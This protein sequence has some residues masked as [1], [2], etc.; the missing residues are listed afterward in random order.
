VV[1]FSLSIREVV[2]SSPVRAGHVKSK[3][4]EIGGDCSFAKNTVFRSENHESFGYDLK[5]G[6]PVPQ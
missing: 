6:G 3:T 5:N 1:V 4:F 2:S